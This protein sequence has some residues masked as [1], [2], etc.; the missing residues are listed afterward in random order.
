MERWDDAE[1]HFEQALEVNERTRARPWVAR[2]KHAYGQMLSASGDSQRG[3]ALVS[4]AQA[5]FRDLGMA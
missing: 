3:G 1:R 4:E 5:S 2:T